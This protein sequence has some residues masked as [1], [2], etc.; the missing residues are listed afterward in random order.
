MT[1]DW[2]RIPWDVLEKISVREVKHVNRVLYDIT[3][4]PP[5][6]GQLRE[7]VKRFSFYFVEMIYNVERRFS[8][9]SSN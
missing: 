9:P 3:P 4:K 5:V 1:S 7:S 2:A 8:K 6:R